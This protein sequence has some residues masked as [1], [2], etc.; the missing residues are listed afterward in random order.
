MIFAFILSCTTEDP[1]VRLMQS[2]GEDIFLPSYKEFATRSE[3]LHADAESFCADPNQT[4]L[5]ELQQAWWKTR[6]PW[7][8]MEILAFGPYK[9]LP[10]RFGVQIDFWPLRTRTA[11][12]ILM[13]D[14]PLTLESVA[15][16][17][18]SSKGLPV[19]E[20]LLYSIL[21]NNMPNQRGCDYLLGTTND[22]A[23]KS[24]A[25]YNAWSPSGN[26]YLGQMV[27]PHLYL[28]EYENI[29]E[30]LAE[31]VNRLGHTLENIR[32]D[33]ILKGLGND[34]GVVQESFIESRFSHRSLQDIRNN[35]EGIHS[36]YFGVSVGQGIDDYLQA[37]GYLLDEDFSSRYQRCLDA[38]NI[39]EQQG[40]L[41]D[42]MHAHPEDVL[43][44]SRVLGEL[45]T[46]IQ[47]E[48]LG[49]M[50]LW[51]TFNDADGD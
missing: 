8:Q 51:L 29:E 10:D 18:A 50:S 45:Q 26:N 7:K 41:I 1:R 46:L 33:K 17:G 31:I 21:T 15:A 48:I 40:T 28:G 4:S 16:L 9:N 42:N 5:L 49:A 36:V 20:Y 43:E 13:G 11:D 23:Q 2:W 39:L 35:L 47:G 44:L 24:T 37:R 27:E 12:E 19:I 38:I 30:S 32:A 3:S 6:E 25:I 14:Q 22:L 34:I